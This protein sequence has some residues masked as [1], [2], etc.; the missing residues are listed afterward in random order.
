MAIIESKVNPRAEAFKN[1]DAAMRDKLA[2]LRTR[3]GEVKQGGG[4]RAR[5][6]HLSRG[7]L[8]PRDRIRALID[9]GAPFLE[10]SQLA[11]FEVYD[12]NIASG[13]VITGIGRVAGKECLII[14]NDATV[15]G[16]TYY[17][18]TVK[19]TH[20]GAGKSRCKT[21]CLASIWSTLVGPICRNGPD[22]F[23]DRDHFGRIFF[24][25]ANMSRRRHSADRRGHG[26]LH[27]GRRLCASDVG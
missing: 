19:N 9:R 10:F 8:L 2:V 20:P 14:A 12:D 15:K 3:V 17:S 23:P 7:K 16:G 4:E 13:G 22:V 27:G 25:Q 24:N 11:A 6:R 26:V 18:I 1:N 5:S 21:I